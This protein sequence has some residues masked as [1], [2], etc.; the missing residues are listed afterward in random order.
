MVG[1]EVTSASP[2]ARVLRN[3]VL[4]LSR[5]DVLRLKGM[6]D[7]YLSM[8]KDNVVFAYLVEARD[9]LLGGFGD[10]FK[11]GGDLLLRLDLHLSNVLSNQQ[12][13]SH[14]VPHPDDEKG[15]HTP[16]EVLVA[17]H[18]LSHHLLHIHL[19]LLHI[20]NHL[21]HFRPSLFFHFP[22]RHL[23]L[24]FP[25]PSQLIVVRQP[26]GDRVDLLP[27][28]RNFGIELNLVERD[29]AFVPVSGAFEL[30]DL[31]TENLCQL[32]KGYGQSSERSDMTG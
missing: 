7:E 15:T 12:S 26:Q 4:A 21:A 5:A 31:I 9:S 16:H 22:Q 29:A 23:K 19:H 18:N 24:S 20:L 28:T 3:F 6:S 2:F 17:F 1:I 30:G 27:D 8:E 11:L 13:V 25:Y 10:L 32:T 14:A